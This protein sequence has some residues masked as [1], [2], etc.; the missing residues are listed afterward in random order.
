MPQYAMAHP[1]SALSTSSNNS[2]ELAIPERMLVPH[3]AI[4]APLCNIIAGCREM[5]SPKA[6]VGFSL[7]KDGLWE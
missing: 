2:F 3:G 4:E 5:N 1:G 6:L 7:A